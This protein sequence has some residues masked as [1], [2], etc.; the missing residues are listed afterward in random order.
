MERRQSSDVANRRAGHFQ[1]LHAYCSK[2][3]MLMFQDLDGYVDICKVC[4]ESYKVLFS[5][6]R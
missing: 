4:C 2:N 1:V 3:S 5:K 6:I